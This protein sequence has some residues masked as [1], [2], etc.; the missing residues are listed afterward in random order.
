MK[1]YLPAIQLLMPK[2]FCLGRDVSPLGLASGGDLSLSQWEVS[3][4]YAY[5]SEHYITEGLRLYSNMLYHPSIMIMDAISGQARN[6]KKWARVDFGE[7]HVVTGVVL[8]G[9]FKYSYHTSQAKLFFSTDGL[10]F[11]QVGGVQEIM[12]ILLVVLIIRY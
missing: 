4:E 2:S 9:A 8:R 5:Y 7:I 12:I 6:S 11:F 1:E 3:A 10:D